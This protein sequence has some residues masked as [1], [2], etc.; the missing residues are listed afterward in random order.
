[1]DTWDVSLP[2]IRHE[3]KPSEVV[4]LG[5][6]ELPSM[7]LHTVAWADS[8]RVFSQLT[9][10]WWLFEEVKTN[11]DVVTLSGLLHDQHLLIVV[12][13][14]GTFGL[15][16]L[17]RR[18][19]YD[20][21]ERAWRFQLPPPRAELIRRCWYRKWFQDIWEPV[22]WFD[23]AP[24]GEVPR[25]KRPRCNSTSQGPHSLAN[26]QSPHGPQTTQEEPSP[27]SPVLLN[28]C[29]QLESREEPSSD[30]GQ[31]AT[32]SSEPGQG[33]PS[34]RQATGDRQQPAA[35]SRGA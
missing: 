7:E 30:A 4:L 23:R 5:R 12:L 13:D 24:A 22:R 34:W 11:S 14:I 18:L 2:G 9:V 21:F 8:T 6:W 32:V 35:S 16:T 10:A 26:A 27:R 28:G 33:S 19:V 25:N 1:M 17:R 3:V 31:S 20:K 29:R 15:L